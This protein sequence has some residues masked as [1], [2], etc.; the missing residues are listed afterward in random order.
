MSI[1][2][3]QSQEEVTRYFFT[4]R[5]PRVEAETFF[6]YFES[7]GWKVGGRAPMK[8]WQAAARNWCRRSK[9]KPIQKQQ[10][11]DAY[12]LAQWKR[13]A[14]PPPQEFLNIIKG[15]GKSVD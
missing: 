3:P 6:D 1:E 10:S 7:N 2:R 11:S 15:I 9:T 14:V 8:N 13:E 4:L 5:F 12:Q